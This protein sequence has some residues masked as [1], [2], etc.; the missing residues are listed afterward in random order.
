MTAP[1]LV[2]FDVDGTLVDS[3]A[4]I[5]GA[6]TAMYADGGREAPARERLLSIVGLSLPV[7]V[8]TLEPDLAIDEVDRWVDAYRAAFVDARRAG[9]PSPLY[10]GAREAMD[11]LRAAP[12]VLIGVATGKSRKGL[13]HVLETHGLGSVFATTQTADEHPSK[14]HPSM[15][16]SAL[17]ETGMAPGRAV[18]VGDTTFD[19][20]MGRAAGIATIGV[21]W[22]YHPPGTLAAAGASAVIASFADLPGTVA[23]LLGSDR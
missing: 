23:R 16:E 12:G 10:P 17:G 22:G 21:A 8:A 7:A 20:E 6:L 5:V 1:A 2:L 18:I 11:A 9:A 13:A 19:I 4:H 15:V 14:P 3:Q